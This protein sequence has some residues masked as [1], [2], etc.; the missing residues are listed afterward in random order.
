MQFFAM[1]AALAADLTR[2]HAAS[3]TTQW[4]PLLKDD[5]A[6][7]IVSQLADETDILNMFETEFTDDSWVGRRKLM[8]IKI[9]RN[10]SVGSIP[11]RGRLPNAGRTSYLDFDIGIRNAYG[12]VGFGREIMQQSRNKKGSWQQVMPSEMESLTQ[13][14]SFHR[15]RAMWGYGSGI[16]ALVNGAQ[17]ADTTIEVDSPGN[18]AGSI[19]GNRFLHGDSVSGMYVAFLDASNNIQ[20]TATITGWAANGNSITVD[21]AVTCDDNAKVV[22]AQSPLQTSYNQEIEGFLAA[23]DD[24]TYVNVYHG[25]NR[26][27]YPVLKSSV[28][29][30]VGALSLDAIQQQIDGNDIRVRKNADVLACE[31]AVRRAY[32]T[33]LET[34]RRYSGAD[35][36]RPDGG[37][38]AAKKPSGKTI[39]YGDI[40]L[41]VSRDAPYG[42]LFGINK[43]SFVRYVESEGK[44]ADDD[45]SV[46]KWVPEFDEYTA[47]FYV[48][49]NLHCQQPNANWRMEGINVN[50]IIAHTF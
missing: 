18:V 50:Q 10:W 22:I 39:T 25:L 3:D 49:D 6:P 37:T 43:A 33:L 41:V 31:H 24:G 44:W 17:S 40:P 47:F 11:A 29:T 5:Y 4:D 36:M 15:N 48:Y 42:M 34:D 28:T 21:S 19:M 27:T 45:G 2:M 32:L 16:L 38:S 30:G 35:L 8:P 26:T 46:L 12:R 1:L 23:I 14:L 13:D 7:V 9:G 20:G